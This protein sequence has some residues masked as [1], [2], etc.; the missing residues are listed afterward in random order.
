[1]ERFSIYATMDLG[2]KIM[3]DAID[4]LLRQKIMVA[5]YKMDDYTKLLEW[6]RSNYGDNVDLSEETERGTW[7]VINR[8]N[9][10]ILLD[11]EDIGGYNGIPVVDLD[12]L[13][14]IETLSYNTD[15]V[16]LDGKNLV[17]KRPILPHEPIH[18]TNEISNLLRLQDVD[19]V[20]KIKYIV[21]SEGKEYGFL[22]EELQKIT[23]SPSHTEIIEMFK[24]VN[25]IHSLGTSHGDIKPENI[26]RNSEGQ[27]I[28]ID[29]AFR[30]HTPEYMI[31][32]TERLESEK[33]MMS[34]WYT[35]HIT[36][37]KLNQ[38]R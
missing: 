23:E 27:I 9:G 4:Y 11:L 35:L 7:K 1:M 5:C 34:D 2:N 37:N 32:G 12:R 6:I 8:R 13:K 36:I 18:I 29:L 19:G 10:K 31:P 16:T 3:F 14:D 24:T 25:R 20:V 38:L 22:M 28:F 17:W 30:D 15:R 26:M 33:Y 21:S